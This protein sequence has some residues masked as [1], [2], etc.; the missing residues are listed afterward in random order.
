MKI[1]VSN[2]DVIDKMSILRI[3]ESRI[4]DSK[5]LINIKREIEELLPSLTEIGIAENSPSY[6]NLLRVNEAL[7]VA[8]DEIRE[9]ER[10]ELFDNEFIL[11]AR[12]IYRLNDERCT[13]KKRINIETESTL[14]EEKSYTGMELQ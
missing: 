10:L 1:E 3:K 7:W 5:K 14:V 11:I 2:G 13:L 8:E 6:L 12:A 9:K 4:E